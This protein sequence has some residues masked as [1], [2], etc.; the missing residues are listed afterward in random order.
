M[1]EVDITEDGSLWCTVRWRPTRLNTETLVG[2]AVRERL[3]ELFTEKY[4]A[5]A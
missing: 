3:K 1:D 4:G 2:E 5:E